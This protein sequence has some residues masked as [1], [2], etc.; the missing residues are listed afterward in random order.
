MPGARA[1]GLVCACARVRA[2][3][4]VRSCVSILSALCGQALSGSV[5]EREAEAGRD[6]PDGRD[7]ADVA[8]P[9]GPSRG[10]GRR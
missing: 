3:V 7:A 2:C 1:A 5:V 10:P 4:F 8:E 9:R 6:G